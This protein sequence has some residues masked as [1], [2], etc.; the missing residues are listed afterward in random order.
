MD[1]KIY[2]RLK[3]RY[4]VDEKQSI[5][6]KDVATVICQGVDQ[7]YVENLIL[8]PLEKEVKQVKVLDGMEVV[9]KIY[10]TLPGVDIQLIGPEQT[11][12]YLKR[13]NKSP[14]PLLVILVWV[15]L[16]FGAGIAIMNFH[17][18]VSMREVHIRLHEAVTGEY[19]DHPLW[20]QI[21]YSIGLGLGMI[22]FFNHVFSKRVNEEPSPMEIEMFNYEENL[23]KYIAVNKDE[24]WNEQND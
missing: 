16:F 23:D 21:P 2:F 22:L 14:R 11:I 1:K 19:T 12:I 3:S 17:E 20:L 4:W 13:V 8:Y 24:V 18:D 10:S 5:L 15:L 9:R 7:T 6:L